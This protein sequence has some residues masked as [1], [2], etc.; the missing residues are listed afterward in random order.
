MDEV[1]RF[2]AGHSEDGRRDVAKGLLLLLFCLRST[3]I[4]GQS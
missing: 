2:R 3:Q 4:C 1:G